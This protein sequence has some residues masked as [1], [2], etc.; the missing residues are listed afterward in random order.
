MVELEAVHV[1]SSKFPE[2][3]LS[4]H[5][6]YATFK[7]VLFSHYLL[8]SGVKKYKTWKITMVRKQI[9]WLK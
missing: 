7:K 4:D 3:Q 5:F 6:H 1:I 2:S 8:D 9:Q